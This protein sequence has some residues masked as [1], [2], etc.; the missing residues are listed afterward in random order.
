M[1][2]GISRGSRPMVRT[3]PQF[4]LDCSPPIRPF[5]QSVTETPRCARKRAVLTPAMPPPTTI[6]S[7]W[8]GAS[9]SDC[10]GS[11][12]GLIVLPQYS[13]EVYRSQVGKRGRGQA[14]PIGGPAP[15]HSRI[16][17]APPSTGLI[18]LPPLPTTS[19]QLRSSLMGQA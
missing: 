8:T 12:L 15:A 13:M 9:T 4:R 18:S 11:T 1:L 7:E 10:T 17:S 3:Q 16:V 6:T 2:S 5:S 14:L 19:A